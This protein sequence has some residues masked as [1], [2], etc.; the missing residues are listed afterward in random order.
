MFLGLALC[1]YF[2]TREGSLVGVSLGLLDGLMIGTGEV[3][4]VGLSLELPLGFPF[5]YKNPGAELSGILMGVPIGFWFDSEASRCLCYCRRLMD[6]HED[7]C[8]GV[9]ISCVSPS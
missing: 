3:Y 9:G 6:Y 5:E 1:N 8:W 4:L 7:T 2:G